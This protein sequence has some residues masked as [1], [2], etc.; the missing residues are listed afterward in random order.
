M[1]DGTRVAAEPRG[2]DGGR[3]ISWWSESWTLFMKNPGLW[4]LFGVIMFVIFAVLG[5]I[6]FIGGIA[7]LLLAPVFVG[8]WMLAARKVDTG[9]TLE[10]ND[11]FAGFQ[12]KLQPLL[13]VGAL[14]LAAGVVMGLIVG[15]LGFGSAMGFMMGGSQ[16]GAGMAAAM[17][18]G[19]L[20]MLVMLV[21][22][23]ILAMAFWFAP[24][25]VVFRDVAPVD[26]LKA[27]FA[28][29]MKNVVAFLLYGILYIVAAIIASIPFGLGWIV[30]IPLVMLS[31]YVSYRD[32]FA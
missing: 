14:L 9:G 10:L 13:I 15:A 24:P 20:A 30:L 6:P 18:A 21:L 16:S 4:I 12:A 1:D 23:F 25:L 32:V 28:A 11:L 29:S 27:S 5:F 22:G 7:A 17:G 8:S 19:M 2:V 3:G 31:V 26:A